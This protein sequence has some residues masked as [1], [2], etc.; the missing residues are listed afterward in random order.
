LYAEF[1]CNF[2]KENK[3]LASLILILIPTV[4]WKS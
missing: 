2:V 4:N 1:V 3:L